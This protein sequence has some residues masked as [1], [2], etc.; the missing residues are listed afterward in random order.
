MSKDIL[1]LAKQQEE[2]IIA[3]LRYLHQHPELSWQEW[4][5]TAFI[6]QELIKNQ[7]S[8]LYNDE[9]YNHSFSNWRRCLKRIIV[10]FNI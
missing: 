10:M 9:E 1:T 4:E 5:T 6:E 3:A 7:D 8:G 2:Y